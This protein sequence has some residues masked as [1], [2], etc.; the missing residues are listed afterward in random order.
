MRS[1]LFSH[2]TSYSFLACSGLWIWVTMPTPWT[3]VY[4]L[5][6]PPGPD[7]LTISPILGGL[8]GGR[9]AS[10]CIAPAKDLD[11]VIAHSCTLWSLGLMES[12]D[13][14]NVIG[15]TENGPQL[16]RDLGR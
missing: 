11:K 16:H 15:I 10:L 4:C 13:V 5:P 8:S 12:H 7:S 1:S 2:F 14:V 9:R 3:R 6:M